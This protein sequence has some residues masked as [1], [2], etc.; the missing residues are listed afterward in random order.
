MRKSLD[1]EHCS[2]CYVFILLERSI[3]NISLIS[4]RVRQLMLAKIIDIYHVLLRRRLGRQCMLC[5]GKTYVSLQSV[6]RL[7]LVGADGWWV[8]RSWNIIIRT[9]PNVASIFHA[10]V[11][12]GDMIYG[13]VVRGGCQRRGSLLRKYFK[14]YGADIVSVCEAS[15]PFECKAGQ[16]ISVQKHMRS[17]K[18]IEPFKPIWPYLS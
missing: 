15:T 8:L 10:A 17:V 3:R 7:R 11:S 18:L 5:E 2:Q 16:P 13:H 14:F 1:S 4:C 9:T 6:K 12:R